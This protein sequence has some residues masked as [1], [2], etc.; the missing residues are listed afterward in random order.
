MAVY[1]PKR[2]HRANGE[3]SPYQL[4]GGAWRGAL[5]IGWIGDRP[6]RKF[7]RADTQA[8]VVD[9]LQKARRDL[10]LGILSQ[11]PEKQ[12]LA[13]YL[14]TWLTDV[15]TPRCRPKTLTHYEGLIR[16]HIIPVIGKVPLLKLSPQHVQM[17]LTEKS[18][19]LS[20]KTC[21]HLRTCLRVALG[22]AVKW[23]LI[24]RNA[25]ALSDASWL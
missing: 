2:K 19:T 7:F 9:K 17:M 13:E 18:A 23:N 6:K 8:A 16:L 1:R 21:Q 5:T 20:P 11:T 3:G 4:A 25:A 14:T 15:A 10:R 24:Q 22:T 12:T